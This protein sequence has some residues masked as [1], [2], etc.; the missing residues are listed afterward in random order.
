MTVLEQID[1]AQLTIDT[2]VRADV[3]LDKTFLASIKEHGVIQP[4]VAHRTEDGTLHIV[5]GQ[6]LL[7]PRGCTDDR[8]APQVH[9]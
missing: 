6:R 7:S 2:N 1:P 8:L 3:Q 5:Y 4:V 9:L